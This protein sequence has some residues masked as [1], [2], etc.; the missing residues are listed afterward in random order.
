[1]RVMIVSGSVPPEPCGVGDHAARL[2]REL[3]EREG[4]E[5]AV[6][7][8]EW[9][10]PEPQGKVTFFPV[11]KR[12]PGGLRAAY[13]CLAGWKPDI[14]HIQWP[15]QG[16][17]FWAFK[18]NLLALLAWL[19]G[20]RLV[21]SWHEP[22][23]LETLYPLSAQPRTIK[24]IARGTSYAIKRIWFDNWISAL[25]PGGLVL[26]RENF[27]QLAPF[28]LRCLPWLKTTIHVQ[29]GSTLPRSSLANSELLAL[30]R[31]WSPEG[32]K[33]ILYFGFVFRH[34]GVHSL[35]DLLSPEEYI[36][37]MA[38][39]FD[40]NDPYH[41]EVRVRSQSGAWA[42]NVH[43][44]GFLPDEELANLIAL[45]DAVVL[46]FTGGGGAWNTSV[47]AVQNQG[48]LLVTTSQKKRGYVNEEN[49]F[50]AAP[51]DLE[52]LR[53]GLHTYVGRKSNH[54]GMGEEVWR[55]QID[56]HIALYQKL[57]RQ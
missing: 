11:V 28:W 17:A 8:S 31:K 1:M 50:Y 43:L 20:Y 34:K 40:S 25:L 56:D 42:G 46:P 22:L 6:L 30:R 37:L 13:T 57:K 55:H 48:T 24:N 4:V 2:A 47:L 33:I 5:V 16:Y 29:N 41:A 18:H 32:K 52:A 23:I 36:L 10:K 12:G 3:S 54:Q 38:F 14:V 26:V 21:F 35:F 51:N 7:T 45:A 49:T 19:K 9:I 53:E 15:T 44:L 39:N 27:W